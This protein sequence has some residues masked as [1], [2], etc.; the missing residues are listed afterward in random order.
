MFWRISG[1]SASGSGESTQAE[2]FGASFAKTMSVEAK[3]LVAWSKKTLR[4]IFMA[5]NSLRLGRSGRQQG[6]GLDAGHGGLH[7]GLGK[8]AVVQCEDYGERFEFERHSHGGTGET[9]AHKSRLA[10]L[11]RSARR[12]SAIR[13][14]ARPP[15]AT[16]S[17]SSS[18]C[19]K[20]TSASVLPLASN[21]LGHLEPGIVSYGSA[22]DLPLEFIAPFFDGSGLDYYALNHLPSIDLLLLQFLQANEHLLVT[23]G[24]FRF[25]NRKDGEDGL[26]VSLRFVPRK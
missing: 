18:P 1:G 11:W 5:W 21:Q 23:E 25:L 16:W 8:Q 4:R 3:A 9:S 17:G 12:F 26:E 10:P 7:F 24:I 22:A 13:I 6:A 20:V 14:C 15:F 19:A 2:A